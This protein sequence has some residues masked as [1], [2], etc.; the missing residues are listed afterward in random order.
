MYRV[1]EMKD[2]IGFN[3]TYL[4]QYNIDIIL[5]HECRLVLPIPTKSLQNLFFNFFGSYIKQEKNGPKP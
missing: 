1:F 3:V 2:F 4:L 5:L